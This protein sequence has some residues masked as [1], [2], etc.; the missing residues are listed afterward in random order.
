MLKS[1][2]QGWS[3]DFLHRALVLRS[4]VA[5]LMRVTQLAMRIAPPREAMAR[6]CLRRCCNCKGLVTSAYNFLDLERLESSD[7]LRKWILYHSDFT[8]MQATTAELAPFLFRE[9]WGDDLFCKVLLDRWN[10]ALVF[11]LGALA[12]LLLLKIACQ[13]DDFWLAEPAL[14]FLHFNEINQSFK[15]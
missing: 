2:D 6:L 9:R 13:V 1:F 8:S 11:C 15:F 10:S 12:E 14:T 5:L 3:L 4:F 7:F